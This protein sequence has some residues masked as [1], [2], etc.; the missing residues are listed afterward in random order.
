MKIV[1]D[2]NMPYAQ[3]LFS[4]KGQVVRVPG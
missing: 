3:E 2:E 1:V 4:R